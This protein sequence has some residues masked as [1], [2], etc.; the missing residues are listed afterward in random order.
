MPKRDDIKSVL[1]IGSGPI[2]IGQACEFDYSGTQAVRAL[3][4]EG[5]R[6][7]LVNS[8]P[9]HHH[10]RPRAGRP[11]LRRA[12]DGGVRREDH[13][14]RAPRRP[15]AH[16]GRADRAQPDHRAGQGRRAGQVRRQADRRAACRPSRRA[17]TASCSSRPCRRSACRCRCRATPARWRRAT[18]SRRRSP[19]PAGRA[20][21]SSC[22]PSFTMG[23]SGAAIAWNAEEFDSKL[24]WG[25]QQSPRGEVLV[26]QSV[27][28]W[29]EY[30]LEIMRD[31]ND[32]AVIVCSIEN[33]DPMGIHT[34]DS[35]HHRPGHDPDRQGV[36]GHAG[37]GHRGHPRD[38]RRDRRLEHPVRRQPA[39]PAT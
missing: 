10:D 30:E 34:G 39:R 9:G 38:R 1:L 21:R 4:E 2:V 12:A 28:G 27:L 13:R 8:Q 33:L 7:V 5:F 26:E 20:S 23:G 11:H 31:R 37:R 25:L 14:P 22:G 32:N 16:P 29:K 17:R 24:L 36:P 15:A 3:K 6:V 19:P 18:R 35:H